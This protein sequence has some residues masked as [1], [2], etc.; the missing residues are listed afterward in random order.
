MSHNC[1]VQKL[2]YYLDL[3]EPEKA[4][5]QMFEKSP[6]TYKTGEVVI[7]EGEDC[8]TLFLISDG[9]LVSSNTLID[10]RR[11]ILNLNY[12]GD[13]VGSASIAFNYAS[14]AVSAGE[15]STLCRFPKKAL[16]KLYDDHP[17]LA[18]LLHSIAMLE[19]VALAD[20]LKTLGSSSGKGKV[21][22]LLLEI[23]SRLR[24]TSDRHIDEFEM[25]LTQADIGDAIGLTQIHVN[26]LLRQLEQEDEAIARQG[27]TFRV[28]RENFLRDISSFSNRYHRID[29]SWFPDSRG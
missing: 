18:A 8:D 27:R 29:T 7:E 21:A 13:I 17:R 6:R 26:R 14:A 10:G 20:R 28:L 5:L 15:E 4:A 2:E 22:A 16:T 24:T 23:L 11:Q 25:R 3:T 1:L 9:W 19:N 12:P